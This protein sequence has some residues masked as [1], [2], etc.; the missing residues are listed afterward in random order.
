LR[1]T[2]SKENAMTDSQ[3]VRIAEAAIAVR[4]AAIALPEC[5]A[6]GAAM[7]NARDLRRA[8]SVCEAELERAITT[9]V[10]A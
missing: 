10:E 3:A 1:I 9:T 6:R 2:S 4:D 5:E 7:K 8:L